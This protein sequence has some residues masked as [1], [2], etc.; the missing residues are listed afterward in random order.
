MRRPPNPNQAAIDAARHLADQRRAQNALMSA[1]VGQQRQL[2]N[3]QRQ[4]AQAAHQQQVA[5]LRQQAQL[6]RAQAA[7]QRATP[8]A[9]NLAALQIAQG[10]QQAAALRA[11]AS[12]QQAQ[13][14]LARVQAQGRRSV[15]PTGSAGVS[16]DGGMDVGLSRLHTGLIAASAVLG[17]FAA[18]LKSAQDRVEAVSQSGG[19]AGQ[20][21]ALSALGI[22]PGRQAAL[23]AGLRERLAAG[24]PAAAEGAR[25]GLGVQLPRPFGNTN[26]ADLLLKAVQR[27]RGM[28]AGS[29]QQLKTARLFGMEGQL[30]RI[31]VGGAVRQRQ[32]QLLGTSSSVMDAGTLKQVNDF[33]E[34]LRLLGETFGLVAMQWLKPFL[35]LLTDLALLGSDLGSGFVKLMED[36]R[37]LADASPLALFLKG[38]KAV[39][40]AFRRVMG[41]EAGGRLQQSFLRLQEAM[42]P[43]MRVVEEK[44]IPAFV[45]LLETI[46]PATI[47]LLATGLEK[48]ATIVTK[49]LA[50]LG[51]DVN[52][53][54]AQANTSALN[55]NTQALVEHGRI[56]KEGTFGGG[57]RSRFAGQTSRGNAYHFNQ[58]AQGRALAMGA[59]A[60]F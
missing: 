28:E 43:V 27:L 38:L 8:A 46:G 56:L 2:Q 39:G 40:E 57:E 9:P 6:Q 1:W 10:R 48:F 34:S 4:M 24:G 5:Q 26:E 49:I 30:S 33:T 16:S 21:A 60:L 53:R 42:V 37:P 35:P 15:A 45:K 47:N 19:T 25:Q 11:G 55:A 22:A 52:S 12:L 54:L 41:G 23:A 7:L 13:L 44:L 50:L 32:D 14:R 29:A 18:A 20:V 31:N 59:F 36:L 58:A 51:V 3:V 17:S